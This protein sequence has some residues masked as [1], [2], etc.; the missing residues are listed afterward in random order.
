[1]WRKFTIFT[2]LFVI[3]G[4][5]LAQDYDDDY[6]GEEYDDVSEEQNMR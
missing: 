4:V 1:M 3:F 6:Y 2:T 5:T